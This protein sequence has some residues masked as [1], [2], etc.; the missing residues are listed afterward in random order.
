MK[1]ALVLDVSA[2]MPWCCD[3]ETTATSEELLEWAIEGTALHVPALWTSEILNVVAV[4]VKRGRITSERAKEFLAQLGTL[5]FH[6]DP[7]P[8]I[9]EFPRLQA[10]AATHGLTAYDVAYWT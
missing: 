3:D 2:C 9:A 6:I 5:N 1:E 10:L 7:P 8:T 4:T